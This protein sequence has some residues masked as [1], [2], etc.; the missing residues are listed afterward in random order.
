MLKVSIVSVISVL[1]VAGAAMA[2]T[3]ITLKASVGV[4][5]SKAVV[6]RD[7]AE[8]VGPDATRLGEVR[9]LAPEMVRAG[10]AG[11]ISLERASVKTLLEAAG[12]NWARTTLNGGTVSVMVI[13]PSSDVEEIEGTKTP[14]VEP[15]VPPTP[16]PTPTTPTAGAMP[17]VVP[18][19]VVTAAPVVKPAAVVPPATTAAASE[20]TMRTVVIDRIAQA[21]SLDPAT[22]RVRFEGDDAS[23]KF[24]NDV[25]PATWSLDIAPIG[26]GL[27]GRTPVRI[28]AFEGDRVALRKT[29]QASVLVRVEQP[30]ATGVLQR[31]E[32]VGERDIE[33]QE[34]WLPPA[35]ARVPEMSELMG[36]QL[37]RRIDSGKP[38]GINDIQSPLVINRGDDV[39]VQAVSGSIVIKTKAKALSSAREG[40]RVT[41]QMDGSKKTITGR[42]TSRGT[43]VVSLDPGE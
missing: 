23:L 38:I 10:T 12:V 29:V 32:I 20:S 4:V 25:V 33:L 15:S 3:A 19:T 17:T 6:L 16:T 36:A 28:E 39:T 21:M 26:S 14:V 11:A 30:V 8:I 24:L 1:V 35:Q 7:V 5:P 2:Q 34:R 27:T 13:A 41:L 31:G 18:G 37:K 40:E 9:L 22:M 43:A 42:A